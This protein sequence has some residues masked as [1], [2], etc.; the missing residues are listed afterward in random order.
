[1]ENLHTNFVV[2]LSRIKTIYSFRNNYIYVL[3]YN[4]TNVVHYVGRI[5]HIIIIGRC[6]VYFSF[7]S[8]ISHY[9]IPLHAGNVFDSWWW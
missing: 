1:M 8:Q 5:T 9:I 3:R 2:F 7:C 6:T 4:N